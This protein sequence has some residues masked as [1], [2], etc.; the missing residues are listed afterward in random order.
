YT[1]DVSGL[2]PEVLAEP[3]GVFVTLPSGV[4]GGDLTVEQFA[5]YAAAR[6]REIQA[7]FQAAKEGLP[8]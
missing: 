6:W 8:Q 3:I 5:E 1:G 4:P 7:D 2:P